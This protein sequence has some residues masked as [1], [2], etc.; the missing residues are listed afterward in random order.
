MPESKTKKTKNTAKGQGSGPEVATPLARATASLARAATWPVRTVKRLA[1]TIKWRAPT[2]KRLARTPKRP[3]RRGIIWSAVALLV[4]GA[5][6]GA[7]IGISDWKQSVEDGRVEASEIGIEIANVRETTADVQ[8]AI[9]MLDEQIAEAEARLDELDTTVKTDVELA[10][11]IEDIAVRLN[12]CILE[13][14]GFIE[15]IWS[16]Q[17]PNGNLVTPM[18]ARCDQAM[19]ELDA[20]FPNGSVR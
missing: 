1:R 7:W 19:K 10:E 18:N 14:R 3:T 16:G 5:N 4:V 20:I 17:G 13:R 9:E 12:A 8:A 2:A 11:H 15:A 6:V